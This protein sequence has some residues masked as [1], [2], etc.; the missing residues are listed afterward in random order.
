MLHECGSEG[1]LRL[2]LAA[3]AGGI[4]SAALVGLPFYGFPAF[5]V[6][7]SLVGSGLFAFCAMV[8]VFFLGPVIGG[9]VAAMIARGMG[10]GAL[11][12]FLSG[13]LPGVLAV[14]LLPSVGALLGGVYGGA[15]GVGFG[16]AS[17]AFL[18]GYVFLSCVG[19]GLLGLLGGILG[20]RLKPIRAR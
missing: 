5:G 1:R 16:A 18:G 15:E 6:L 2:L 4:V 7:A 12:G 13:V 14:A 17:G 11:A 9:G 3:I 8:A 10:R 19:L 20:G